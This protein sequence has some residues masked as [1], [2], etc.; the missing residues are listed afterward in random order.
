MY[1]LLLFILFFLLLIRVINFFFKGI[2][3]AAGREPGKKY[4][5]NFKNRSK[6]NGEIN[7]DHVPDKK[8]GKFGNDFKGGD[9]VDYEEVK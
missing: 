1:K 8:G 2:Y 3:R 5:N 9:Y 6:K 7:I 4:D